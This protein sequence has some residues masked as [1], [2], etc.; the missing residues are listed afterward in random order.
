MSLND[1][2]LSIRQRLKD[3]FPHYAEK[4]LRIRQ[5]DG[6]VSPFVLN[7]AQLHIHNE[8]E[9]QRQATGRVRA[10]I[11]KGRQQG[12]S[13]YTEGRFYWKTT[14]RKG[15]RAFILT[16]EQ[17]ATDN[18]FEMV[19]RYHQH[20]P[21]AVKPL[22]DSAS[23]KEL[24]FG[25]LDSGYKVG[26]AGSKG[27]GRSSTIQYFHGSE[28]GFWPNADTHAVGVMQAI[29]DAGDTE[30]ILES[31]ANGLGN[32]F[33]EQWKAA[34]S[35][36]SEYVAIFVPWFWQDEYSKPI[37]DSF[38]LTDEEMKLYKAYG[39][40]HEQLNW[41]RN[42]IVELSSGGVNGLTQFQQ[43]YPMS[44]AEAFQM[45]GIETLIT[46]SMV[47]RARKAK[48]QGIGHKIVGVDPSLGGDRFA[49]IC[50]QGSK[51]YGLESYVGDQVNTLEKRAAKCIRVLEE[52]KP[53]MMF[54]DAGFGADLVDFLHMQ[55]Y[56]NVKAISFGGSP[57][58][59]DKYVNKRAE[60]IGNLSEWLNDDN[61][62]VEIPDRDDLQADLCACPY[63]V[64]VH[65]RIKIKEK[66]QIRRDFGFS[67]DFLDA[68]GLTFA[69]KIKPKS[70][71]YRGGHRAAGFMG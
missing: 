57:Q 47:M 71:D 46:P 9:R 70:P 7:K 35:G 38:S 56:P 4:C 58:R 41:R 62:A 49:I 24:S 14:H 39:L 31:T 42:K 53:D 5:K 68:A 44:A 10:I 8:I 45:T 22:T 64:D 43:E 23:A 17:Q 32:Y 2:E 18:L 66:K 48:V 61:V 60:M 59:D 15:V 27:V 6:R 50:R 21:D 11:L 13:T 1:R 55:G 3:D 36:A 26:T 34:E 67:P 65:R 29:P 69:E 20:C 52:E 37:N 40:S 19:C 12:V 33:H 28:V 63:D 54:V 51:M 16:H 30:I 25:Q